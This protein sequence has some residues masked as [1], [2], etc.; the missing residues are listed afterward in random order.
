MNTKGDPIQK[1]AVRWSEVPL[2]IAYDE[3]YLLALL[4]DCVEIRT[5]EPC[6]FIQS[7][8][9]P[10]PRL[11]FRCHQGLVYVAS[12][13]YVWCLQAVPLTQQIHILLEDKQFQLALRLTN[14]SDESDEEKS[15]N[16]YQIQTL[17]AFDLFNNKQFHDSM[18]EFLNLGT[19]PYEV[20]RLFPELLPQQSRGS[21]ELEQRPKLQDRDLEN[22]LLALIEFL[23]EVRHKLMGDSKVNTKSDKQNNINHK[24]TQQ[25]LQIIDTTLLK[26]Y[27][28]TN[29]ALVAP[30]L[31]LNHCHLGETEKTLKKHQKYSELIILYQT[32]GLHRKALELLQKQAEYP[33]S[34]LQG[35]ER[36]LQYLQHLGKDHINLILD[37]AGWVLDANPEEGLKIFTEDIAEV[38]Q[39]PRPKVLDYLL[40]THK[41]LVIP[42]LEHV[43][44]VWE[45]S[46]PIFHNALVHQYRER[47]QQLLAATSEEGE[48]IRI[49]LLQFLETSSQYTPETVLVHFPYDCLFEERAIVLGKLGRHEHAL[50]IYMSILRDVPRAVD[51][52]DKVYNQGSAGCDEV[53][54]LLMKMLITP[55]D[56]SWL[57]VG[58]QSST[59]SCPP[60]SDLETALSVLE[61]HASK[62]H[63]MKALRVLPDK[64]PLGRIRQFLEVSLQNKLNERRRAQVLKGLIYAEH[65]QVQELRMSYESQSILMTEFNV[66]PVCK[67][68][69]GNQSAF[70]RYPNGDIVHYSCQERRL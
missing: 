21:Q 4:A 6:L 64:V 53:Y 25:L 48:K 17:Y 44:H 42:Y 16:I 2:A 36:T 59:V 49:K 24:S 39:L 57:V 35:Y 38:E 12:I 14:I 26:C 1:Y 13:D 50:A 70:A 31:R 20:I 32:K 33:D 29:D 10:K 67:K 46:N 43:V 5:V 23:T 55:P 47:C 54:V 56:S 51:Y 69:F 7:V 27:L 61:K 63:P 40:R 62:I 37:F 19:D 58:T 15:K 9:L 11:V 66:C 45:D 34:T 3:P 41:D 22:G 18:K 65:L 68:R 28:Q 60:T 8:P 52:C 30:L